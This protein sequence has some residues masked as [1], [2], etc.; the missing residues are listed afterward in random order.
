MTFECKLNNL[1]IWW[2]SWI[3]FKFSISQRVKMASDRVLVTMGSLY[4]V[5]HRLAYDDLEV[6]L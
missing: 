4:K 5:I 2:L 6:D 1:F 3:L